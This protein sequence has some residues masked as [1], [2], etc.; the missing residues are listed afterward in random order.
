MLIGISS[1]SGARQSGAVKIEDTPRPS[2]QRPSQSKPAAPSQVKENDRHALPPKVKEQQN[3][4]PKPTTTKQEAAHPLPP[5]PAELNHA[6][7][8][9]LEKP[10]Q[11]QPEKRLKVEP[12]H[13]PSG[14]AKGHQ[15]NTSDSL[16][17]L[18]GTAT[19]PKPSNP[20]QSQP[21]SVDNTPTKRAEDKKAP[22]RGPASGSKVKDAPSATR[23]PEMPKLLSPLPEYLTSPTPVSFSSGQGEKPGKN[24]RNSPSTMKAESSVTKRK[25]QS[26]KTSP[27]RLPELLPRELPPNVEELL[28]KSK[29]P[30]RKHDTVQA[31]H[32]RSRNPD[33]PGVARKA[34]KLSAAEKRRASKASDSSPPEITYEPPRQIVKLKYKKSMSKDI[35]RILK[36]KPVP[37]RAVLELADGIVPG[38]AAVSKMKVAEGKRPRP[39]PDEQPERSIKRAKVPAKID[40]DKAAT[41]PLLPPFKSPGLAPTSAKKLA[42]VSKVTPKKGDAMK[43]VAMRRVDSA[44]DNTPTP[45]TGAA[46]TPASTEKPKQNGSDP[47]IAEV[48]RCRA[49]NL[50]YSEMGKML[51]RKRDVYIHSKENQLAT[52]AG[53]ESLLAYLVAFDAFDAQLRK[54]GRPNTGDNWLSLFPLL[55]ANH[56]LGKAHLHLDIVILLIGGVATNA[57]LALHHQRFSKEIP[58]NSADYLRFRDAMS[59]NIRRNREFWEQYQMACKELAAREPEAVRDGGGMAFVRAPGGQALPVKT[60]KVEAAKM[61]REYVKRHKLEWEMQVDF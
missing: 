15:R 22:E 1:S 47:K 12:K 23:V 10:E 50:K 2:D 39:V 35:Q 13:T 19:K 3:T 6:P 43:S 17:R 45:K 20:K 7:K 48:E 55:Q 46:S 5:K 21:T 14:A 36:M 61:L 60:V 9:P 8:R 28:A 37:N 52:L 26:E 4:T 29:Q 56:D 41:A 24:G 11:S 57:L 33:A 51:K 40:S 49:A 54:I 32:E 31:R 42:S 30:T 25:E 27:F 59:E 38:K 44:D 58:S 34:P 16:S 53:A 18:F